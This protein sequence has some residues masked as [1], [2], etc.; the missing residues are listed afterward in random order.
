MTTALH[1]ARFAAVL[2]L[3]LASGARTVLDLGCGDGTLLLRLAEVARIERLVGVDQS[4]GAISVLR[5][6]LEAAPAPLAAK[7]SLCEGSYA[8]PDPRLRGFDAAIMVE[9]IE[10]I[11]PERLSAVEHAVFAALAPALVVVTTPNADF[12]PLLGVPDHRMRHPDHRFEWGR[13]RFGTWANGV[14]RRHGYR[15]TL[16]D[17]GGSHPVLGG[18]SQ[19]AVLRR[20]ATPSSPI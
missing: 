14:A 17:L 1:E 7:V 4:P 12:N 6:K 13:A 19:M 15:A 10:H 5:Q 18:P 8:K 3:L 20:Q 2:D 11:D 16:H 9:T